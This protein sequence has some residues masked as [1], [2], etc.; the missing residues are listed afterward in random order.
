YGF[1]VSVPLFTG[2]YYEGEI[3]KAES[4][5]GAARD[6]LDR[7]RALAQAE[8]IRARSDVEAAA[9]RLRRSRGEVL[10]AAEKA[11]DGAEFAYTRGAIGVMDLLDARRQL[12]AARLDVA[13]TQADYSKA[14]AAWRAAST[15]PDTTRADP[16]F[17]RA[18]P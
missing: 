8:I 15:V 12:Y 18:R 11:A 6:G 14:L 5:L 16:P 17:V 1:F 2:N 10:A 9:E 7:V 13:A 3:R 4:D